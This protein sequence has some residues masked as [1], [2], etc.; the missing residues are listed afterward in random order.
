MTGAELVEYLLKPVARLARIGRLSQR[1]LRKESIE[2]FSESIAGFV[3]SHSGDLR[4]AH[5]PGPQYDVEP[6]RCIDS[7]P[8]PGHDGFSPPFG[9]GKAGPS[10]RG[11]L[12]ATS[13]S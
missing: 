2:S 4:R 12:Y 1:K 5:V 6:P 13:P 7:L 3:E 8:S 11:G 9:I 10:W